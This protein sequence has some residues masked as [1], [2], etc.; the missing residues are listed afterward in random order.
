M[1]EDG[2]LILELPLRRRRL[3]YVLAPNL[4]HG[5]GGSDSLLETV[6]INLT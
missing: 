4:I 5:K 1:F 2:M 6:T 3:Q